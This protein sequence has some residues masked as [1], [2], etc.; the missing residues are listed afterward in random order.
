MPVDKVVTLTRSGYTARMISRF[1]IK[2]PI[3]A[4]TPEKRIKK[5]MELSFGVYP[6]YFDYSKKDDHILATAS[7]LLS[8]GLINVKDTILFTAAFRTFKPHSSNLI[9]IHNIRELRQLGET[10]KTTCAYDETV[11]P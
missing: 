6:A 7:K 11:V 2:Q 9:E 8:M 3:I 5:Q 4:V 1:K 10:K